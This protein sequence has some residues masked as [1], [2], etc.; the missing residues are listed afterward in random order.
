MNFIGFLKDFVHQP[1]FGLILSVL[2]CLC[3]YIIKSEQATAKKIT[4]LVYALLF[5]IT[6]SIFTGGIFSRLIH[7]QVYDFTAFY[8]YGK[9]AAT[10][11]DYYLPGNLHAAFNM[12]Q[13]PQLDYAGFQEEIVN[14]GFLYP[15]PTILWFA[16]LGFLSYNTALI[17][18]T[19]FN[20]FILLGCIYLI[21]DLFFKQYKLNGL[22]LV[23]ILVFLFLPV[24]ETVSFSQ[25]NF[26]LLF[27]LLLMNKYPDRKF[28][29]ILLALALFTKP[30]MIV[31]LFVFIL[32]KQWNTILYFIMSS[33]TL[34]GTTLLLFGKGPFISY[35]FSNPSKR[36]PAWVFSEEINQSLHGVLLRNNL[37]TIEDHVS[38]TCILAGGLL[39]TAIY[40]GY[41]VRRKLYNYL[42]V[43]LLLTGLLFYPG[44]LSYYGVLLLFIM[45]QF[46]N[47]K[48]SLGLPANVNIPVVGI[49]YY[50]CSV[51]VFTC[52]CFLLGIIIFK[53]LKPVTEDSVLPLALV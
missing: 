43:A 29:G 49:F 32:K 11:H 26:I 2:A 12:L 13:L 35:I 23:S 47:S 6:F 30:Y 40:L 14:V 46:F 8:L 51:S 9:V 37:I 33:L 27:F 45:F 41:L 5:T 10:G 52:I 39:L 50:L 19:V 4:W 20:L 21:Y 53:S 48:K 18:W 34:V 7:P 1:Y 24:R 44:T 38:Y 36:L 22:M 31:F 42:W 3:F 17:S 15:P 25:T 28:A 16:P